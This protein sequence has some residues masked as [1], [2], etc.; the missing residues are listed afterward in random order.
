MSKRR[1]KRFYAYQPIDLRGID[2]A[3]KILNN[4]FDGNNLRRYKLVYTNQEI[5]VDNFDAVTAMFGIHG[6]TERH[7]I[8]AKSSG[9]RYAFLDFTNRNCISLEYHS[10]EINPEPEIGKIA[11]ALAL[12]PLNRVINSAFVAHGFDEVGKKYAFEV[13]MFL[14]LLGISV[15]TG[16]YY[17]PRSVSDKVRGRIA[18]NDAFVAIVTP[19]DDHTWIIQETTLADSLGKQ[20]IVLVEQTAEHKRGLRGDNEDIYFPAGHVSET[21]NRILQGFHTIRGTSGVSAS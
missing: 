19:Q 2:A 12:R 8:T 13:R 15:V 16:E 9:G 7:A 14:E 4:R 1:V 18:A 11:E 10:S 5:E 21:F 3:R 20:P 17:E 6:P